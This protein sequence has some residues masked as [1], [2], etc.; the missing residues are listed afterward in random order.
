M[1]VY[2]TFIHAFVLFVIIICIKQG[3]GLY[4]LDMQEKVMTEILYWSE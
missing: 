4:V 3:T 1:F 2:Y